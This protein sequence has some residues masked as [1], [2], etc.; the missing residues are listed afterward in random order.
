MKN[1]PKICVYNIGFF[2]FFIFLLFFIYLFSKKGQ[3]VQARPY[4]V[5]LLGRDHRGLWELRSPSL[6]L[7]ATIFVALWSRMLRMT[8]RQSDVLRSSNL[9]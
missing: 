5:I 1:F 4:S 2:I 7:S 3:D 8:K 6:T 9:S